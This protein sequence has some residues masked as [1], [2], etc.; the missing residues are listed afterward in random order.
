M[1]TSTIVNMCCKNPLKSV[2][3]SKC[4]AIW[5]AFSGRKFY[6]KSF[7]K[8]FRKSPEKYEWISGNFLE[9][10]ISRN[11]QTHNPNRHHH[12]LPSSSVWQ[13]SLTLSTESTTSLVSG[14]F[15][16]SLLPGTNQ[17]I[18]KMSLTLTI[19][20]PAGAGPGQI[21]KLKSSRS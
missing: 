20:H 12:Q 8:I 4:T 11:F 5:K 3:L 15:N 18:N 2:V 14:I 6:V 16:T 19:S 17:S 1:Y 9:E 7:Q 10:I 21:H 13:S